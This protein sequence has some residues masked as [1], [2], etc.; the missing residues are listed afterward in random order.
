[1]RATK[2]EHRLRRPARRRRELERF[3]GDGDGAER[4][5]AALRLDEQTAQAEQPRVGAPIAIRPRAM[6]SRPRA[7]RRRRRACAARAGNRHRNRNSDHSAINATTMT[8]T[9]ST[10]TGNEV[11]T[12]QGSIT[13][14]S[15]PP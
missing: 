1:L 15:V 7:S 8:T 6:A 13:S 12:C 4:I 11:S 2:A 5:V 14:V 3:L 10:K 9:A